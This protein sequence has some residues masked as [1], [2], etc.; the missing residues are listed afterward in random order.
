MRLVAY[1]IF[2]L[3]GAIALVYGVIRSDWELIALGGSLL[4][5][6]VLASVNVPGALP[7]GKYGDHDN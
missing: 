6:N 7:R 1:V 3:V 5:T 4:G 2:M